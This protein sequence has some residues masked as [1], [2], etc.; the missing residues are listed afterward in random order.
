MFDFIEYVIGDENYECIISSEV[1]RQ[2]K[3]LFGEV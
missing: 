1:V 3:I 2:S